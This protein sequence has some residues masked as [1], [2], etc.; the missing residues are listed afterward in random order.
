MLFRSGPEEY[1]KHLEES[2][3]QVLAEKYATKARKDASRQVTRLQTERR[4]QRGQAEFLNTRKWLPAELLDDM[5]ELVHIDHKYTSANANDS[6]AQKPLSEEDLTIKLWTLQQTLEGAGFPEDKSRAA[7]KYILDTSDRV[8]L[9]NKD[10]IWG[11]EEAMQ[12]LARE[13]SRDELPDYESFQ[14][15]VLQKRLGTSKFTFA[16]TC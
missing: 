7:V 1:E 4:L 2:E 14:T 13:C 15:K 11:L 6:P 8:V 12:W 3:L 9:G 16:S 10:A 5:L